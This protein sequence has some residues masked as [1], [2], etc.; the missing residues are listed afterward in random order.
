MGRPRNIIVVTKAYRKLSQAIYLHLHRLGYVKES[1]RSRQLYVEEFLFYLEQRG[2]LFIEEIEAGEI[3]AYYEYIS[4]RF[5]RNEAGRILSK[6]T[7]YGHMHAIG[8]LFDMLHKSD[9]IKVNPMSALRFIYPLV[10]IKRTVVTQAEIKQLYEI[11]VSAWE[12]AI[13][14]LAYGCGL[15]VGELQRV[16]V[17]DVRLREKILIIPKGKGNKRRVVPMSSGVAKDLSDYYFNERKVLSQGRDYEE[18]QEAFMLNGRGGRLKG[19]TC[20]KHLKIMME[21]SKNEQLIAKDIT[22]HGLRHSIATHLLE[23][24]IS[25]EQ[26]RQFL[27]HSQLETTQ[28]YTRISQAQLK[29]L[30][31]E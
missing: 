17:A 2:R 23:R 28:I 14:S 24:G 22:M 29:A 4:E 6:K 15:R 18:K 21:R 30:I 5:N 13:L 3:V 20:N 12:R 16:N 10:S 19:H 31:D 25:V 9:Q 11:S 7:T 26:V 27:G 1:C 8:N